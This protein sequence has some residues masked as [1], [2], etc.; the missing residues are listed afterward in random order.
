GVHPHAWHAPTAVRVETDYA[1][2]T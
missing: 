1:Q 2:R